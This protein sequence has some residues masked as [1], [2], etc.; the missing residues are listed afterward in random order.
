M[1]HYCCVPDC[2][3]SGIDEGVSFH[4]FPKE[5]VD[6]KSFKVSKNSFCSLKYFNVKE[7]EESSKQI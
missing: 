3:A 4:S 7:F 2:K 1:V 6:Q 5:D